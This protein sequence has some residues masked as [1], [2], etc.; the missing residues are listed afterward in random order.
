VRGADVRINIS[1][2]EEQLHHLSVPVHRR[3]AQ[4]ILFHHQVSKPKSINRAFAG[5]TLVWVCPATTIAQ[6]SLNHRD[7]TCRRGV[8]ENVRQSIVRPS[9]CY[10]RVVAHAVVHDVC[11][12][13]DQDGSKA[14]TAPAP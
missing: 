12:A 1:M 14:S 2:R 11:Q 7:L 10:P 8:E 3:H 13:H 9:P 5:Y 6:Q 4:R